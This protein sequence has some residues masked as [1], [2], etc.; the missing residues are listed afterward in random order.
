M[1]SVMRECEA[2]RSLSKYWNIYWILVTPKIWYFFGKG[3]VRP[4]CSL[5]AVK[6]GKKYPKFS[7]SVLND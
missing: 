5:A 2:E 1:N 7:E 3:G 4:I 6:S